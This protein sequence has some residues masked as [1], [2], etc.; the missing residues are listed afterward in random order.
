MLVQH[1]PSITA[2]VVTLVSSSTDLPT[3]PRAALYAGLA[4]AWILAAVRFWPDF[5][6]QYGKSGGI[7]LLLFLTATPLFVFFVWPQRDENE[8]SGQSHSPDEQPR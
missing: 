1:P 7:A 8:D 6:R 4:I 3:W 5:K 2:Q